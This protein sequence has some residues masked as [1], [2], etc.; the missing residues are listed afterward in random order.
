M[1][2]LYVVNGLG[3][4]RNMPIGGADKRVA[5]IGKRLIENGVAVHCLTTPEGSRVLTDNSLFATYLLTEKPNFWDDS[6]SRTLLG[7]LLSYIYLTIFSFRSV[8]RDSEGFDI[9]YSSSDYFFDLVP[10]LLIKLRTPRCKIVGISHHHIDWPWRRRGVFWQNWLIFLAQRVDFILLKSFDLIFVPDTPEGN[11]I[12]GSLIFGN[13]LV[14]RFVNGVDLDV[15]RRLPKAEKK[16]D[17]CFLGGFRASKGIFDLVGVW[18]EVCEARPN[19]TLLVIGGGSEEYEVRVRKDVADAGLLGNISF[20]GILPSASLFLVLSS[21]RIIVSPSYEEGWGI[22]ILEA[23]ACGLPVACYDLPSYKLYGD[24]P[25]KVPIGDIK[26][27]A[28]AAVDLLSDERF[29]E[30][31]HIASLR[32]AEKFDWGKAFEKEY[33]ILQDLVK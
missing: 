31:K 11:L 32:L 3:F 29:Y 30:E 4:S 28:G 12:E 8:P 13:H 10:A 15:F 5:E 16:F 14:E 27:L 19:S 24:V 6:W 18:R 20:T 7:R 33:L 1:K 26:R 9:V 2:I 21:A 17:A 25:L 23:M 22:A